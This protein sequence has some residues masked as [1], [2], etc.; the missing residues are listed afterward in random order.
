VSRLLHIGE[1]YENAW[2]P[3]CRVYG[4]MFGIKPST[5]GH[6]KCR[7]CRQVAEHIEVYE[8]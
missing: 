6:G 8:K 7:A 1:W 4:Q 3:L 5:R 2:H